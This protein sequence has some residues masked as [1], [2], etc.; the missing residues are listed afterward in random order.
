MARIIF[1]GFGAVV[2]SVIGDSIGF[3]TKFGVTDPGL[4][5]YVDLS[6][7]TNLADPSNLTDVQVDAGEAESGTRLAVSP[8]GPLAGRIYLE[9]GFMLL[10]NLS[11]PPPG[12][13]KAH[14]HEFQLAYD[15]KG[16]K[17]KRYYGFHA[18]ITKAGSPPTIG[19]YHA[20]RSSPADAFGVEKAMD[21]DSMTAGVRNFDLIT[22]KGGLT[23]I[24]TGDGEPSE[25]ALFIERSF[26]NGI[27]LQ[28]VKLPPSLADFDAIP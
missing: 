20:G 14:P 19:V 9:Q 8:N 18:K 28:M 26:A 23:E 21:L 17:I 7:S 16:A 13:E 6:K 4:L 25:G 1:C 24:G 3:W 27:G 12:Y 11:S 15:I 22:S 10:R 5:V 2:G